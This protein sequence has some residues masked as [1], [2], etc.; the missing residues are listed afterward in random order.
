M[1]T[2]V[3]AQCTGLKV[4]RSLHHCFALCWEAQNKTTHAH[5]YKA[6]HVFYYYYPF[7]I[8]NA[9]LFRWATKIHR[10]VGP[11]LY[12]PY[13]YYCCYCCCCCYYYYYYYYYSKSSRHSDS[14]LLKMMTTMMRF[15][16]DIDDAHGR[17]PQL[18]Y[19]RFS[20]RFSRRRLLFAKSL[21]A[22][23]EKGPIPLE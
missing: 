14:T 20:T 2:S 7:S 21:V 11:K 5:M 10:S 15:R 22:T 16:R 13:Y 1:C 19:K 23:I 6:S 4:E 9:A 18:Q 3:A 8:V 17:R 12:H